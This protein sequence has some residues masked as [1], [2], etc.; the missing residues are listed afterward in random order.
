MLRFQFIEDY[1]VMTVI[2]HTPNIF[3]GRMKQQRLMTLV[4]PLDD[5]AAPP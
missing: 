1:G 4:S 5:N 3:G 2:C